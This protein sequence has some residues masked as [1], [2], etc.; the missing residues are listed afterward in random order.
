MEPSSAG[1]ASEPPLVVQPVENWGGKP[2]SMVPYATSGTRLLALGYADAGA[3]FFNTMRDALLATDCSFEQTDAG[4][5]LCS[6]NKKQRLIYLDAACTEP[7]VEQPA[8]STPMGEIFGFLEDRS[9]ESTSGSDTV[10]VAKHRPAYRVAD[11]VFMS[12]GR[13][14]YAEE[15]ISIYTSS[16]PGHCEG[17]RLANRHVVIRPPSVFRATPVADS[18][19]VKATVRQVPLKD[20]LTLERLVTDDGA[21]LS[22]HL[23][24]AGTEC[25]LQR[26]GRCVPA[27]VAERIGFAD[28]DCKERAFQPVKG[29][30]ADLTRYGVEPTPEDTSKV[31]ELSRTNTLYS[32]ITRVDMV[33]VDGQS[34]A[35]EVV[36]GCEIR[37]VSSATTVYYRRT[38]EITEQLPRLSTVQLGTADLSPIWFFGALSASDTRIQ[39]QIHSPAGDWVKPN[40]RTSNGS[41]CALYSA[42]VNYKNLCVLRDGV[43]TVPVAVVNL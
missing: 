20:G 34:V 11:Q 33:M 17:P 24:L 25:E 27:P 9:T 5:W 1:A 36:I 41:V 35:M 13:T 7:A 40:I 15:A 19:L 16:V 37:D 43:T 29:A 4:D 32:R 6:P 23:L 31:Y 8:D 26:D 28:P 3:V 10:L 42:N 18:E 12:D 14:T 22:G 30:N 2:L 39:V 38:R 21:Q